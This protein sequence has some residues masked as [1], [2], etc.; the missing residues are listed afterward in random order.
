MNLF[1]IFILGMAVGA[2]A[3]WFFMRRKLKEVEREL[4]KK[5]VGS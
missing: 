2:A 4:A 5:P 3:A 1:F